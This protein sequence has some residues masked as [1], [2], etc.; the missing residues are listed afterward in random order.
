MTRFLAAVLLVLLAA[1]PAAAEDFATIDDTQLDL[2]RR[3]LEAHNAEKYDRAAELFRAALL[4]KE[5]NVVYLNLGRALQRGG[6]CQEAEDAYREAL[7]SPKVEN[8]SP[9]EVAATAEKYRGELRETCPGKAT[10]TCVTED[11]ATLTVDGKPA[12]CGETLELPAGAHVAVMQTGDGSKEVQF[13]V[14][15][16]ETAQVALTI[17]TAVDVPDPDD[18]P[19]DSRVMTYVGWGAIGL[20]VVSVATGVYFTSRA[21]DVEDDIAAEGA[22]DRVD[23]SRAQDLL[24]EADSVETGQAVAYGFGAAAL[25]T[26]VVLVVLD[27][28]TAETVTV[29]PLPEGGATVGLTARW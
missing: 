15:G 7:K 20:G 14:A 21:G 27:R 29:S 25:L 10:L 16:L 6:A 4:V 1:T 2:V 3:G 28:D 19:G 12:T 8:P 5:L 23:S 9:K 18:P 22:K 11:E 24:D 13:D 17:D 26:G